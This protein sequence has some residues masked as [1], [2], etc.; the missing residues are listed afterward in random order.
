M[1]HPPSLKNRNKHTKENDLVNIENSI[2]ITR[3]QFPCR[4][5]G[6]GGKGSEVEGGNSDT[7]NSPFLPPTTPPNPPA[8]PQKGEITFCLL[9]LSC[10][11]EEMLVSSS[12][13][14]SIFF[15]YKLIYLLLRDSDKWQTPWREKNGS[16]DRNLIL[17]NSSDNFAKGKTVAVFQTSTTDMADLRLTVVVMLLMLRW[18]HSSLA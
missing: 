18:G 12:S 1:T 9:T 10:L 3:I 6:R 15:V 2:P 4:W 7:L 14:F 16:Y 8:L 11:R 13:G 5:G 17:E